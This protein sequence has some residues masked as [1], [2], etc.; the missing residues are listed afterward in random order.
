MHAKYYSLFLL[1]ILASPLCFAF[2]PST[3][4]PMPIQHSSAAIADTTS[5]VRGPTVN[6][7]TNESALIFWRTEGVTNATVWYGLNTSVIE[8]VVNTTLDTDH[9]I[10][11]TGLEIDSKYFYKVS[12]NNTESA[13]YHFRTAPPDGEE[14]KMIVIGDNRPASI[15]YIQP[16]EFKQLAQMIID[17]A[18]HIVIMSGDYVL[19]VSAD[20]SYNLAG[21]AAF[22]NISDSIGHYAPIYGALGNHDTGAK[23][24]TLRLQY[25]FDA[26]EHYNEP[27]TYFS[28][29]YA[30][31]HF[32]IIDTEIQH[33]EGRIT[34]DQYTWLVNDLESSDCSIKYVVG[35]RPMYPL[36]HIGDSIDSNPTERARLQQ[37]FE[38]Q[39][40]TAYICGHDHLF[41]RLT[42]NG[43][44]HL[45]SG[46]GGA[47]PYDTFWG[48]AYYHYMRI[49][50]SYSHVN[51][52]TIKLNGEIGYNY[53]L[54]YLGPLEIAIRV[55]GNGST[56][57]TGTLPEIYFSEEP[58]Q[59]YYSWDLGVNQT[60]LTGLPNING[61]HSLDV[62]ALDSDDVWTHERFVLTTVGATPT[63]TAPPPL[64]LDPLLIG[65]IAVAGIVVVVV[66]I[67]FRRRQ[68]PLSG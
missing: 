37:L 52:S 27:S 23:T 13:L 60:E 4:I 39:N 9:R 55:L 56:A 2:T 32:A 31:T 16:D 5:F 68:V 25:Y 38:D 49:N 40:V 45:I 41:D 18:P 44:V 14:F 3:G 21:W 59:I 20:D 42:V 29:D 12:S 61:Q 35:H 30:G 7:V 62:Y 33:Y 65:G 15:S 63:T 10:Q 22:T 66:V 28:F 8:S 57:Q 11:L 50:S 26:F 47:P 53:Q 6:L 43:L 19:D 58:S 36:S 48:D 17:E 24:G 1:V 64:V 67:V 54:P 46:G 51:M 34:G